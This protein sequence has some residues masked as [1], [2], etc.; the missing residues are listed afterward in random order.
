MLFLRQLF[1]YG[2]VGASINFLLYVGYLMAVKSGLE[3]KISM[4]IL[5]LV[6]VGI[7]FYSHQQWTYRYDGADKWTLFRFL[8]SHLIGYLVNFAMLAFLVENLGWP[9]QWIQAFAIIV[10]AVILFI[11]FKFWVFPRKI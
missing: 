3:P 9:H 7:G 11:L 8:T 1:R 5:Y 10:V 4:S 2:M 6:G